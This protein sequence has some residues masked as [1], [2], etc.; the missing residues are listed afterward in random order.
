MRAISPAI[1]P[2]LRGS[3]EGVLCIVTNKFIRDM[4]GFSIKIC[5]S[6]PMRHAHSTFHRYRERFRK[7]P[8]LCP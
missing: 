5:M 6:R 8:L 3:A 2:H 4:K 1:C 7:I